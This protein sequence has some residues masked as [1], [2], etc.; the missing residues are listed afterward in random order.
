M[1]TVAQEPRCV[2]YGLYCICH[3]ERGIRYVGQ[4]RTGIRRRFKDHLRPANVKSAKTPVNLWK[5]KHGLSN[6]RYSILEVLDSPEHLNAAEVFWIKEK[7]TLAS[8]GE[9]GLNVEPGG[10]HGAVRTRQ[11]LEAA[12]STKITAEDARAIRSEFSSTSRR[13]DD[14]AARYGLSRAHTYDIIY[15]ISWPDEDYEYTPRN[16]KNWRTGEDC[17][18]SVLTE[19]KVRQI[20]AEAHTGRSSQEMAMEYGVTAAHINQIVSNRRWKDPSYTPPTPEER[21]SANKKPRPKAK[22]SIEQVYEIRKLL[23]AGERHKTIADRMGCTTYNISAI[24]RG[25]T[26]GWLE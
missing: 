10:S 2:I 23:A 1:T 22:L 9:G 6:I 17:Y 3:P 19:E 16:V 18:Q 4:T 24:S 8:L 20:R 26:W 7:R 11:S 12:L 15:N 5:A 21:A 13:V 25:L 14:I